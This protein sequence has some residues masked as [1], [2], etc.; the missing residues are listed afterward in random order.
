MFVCSTFNHC[1]AD[2]EGDGSGG[3]GDGGGGEG[4]GGG[5]EGGVVRVSFAHY[6]TLEEVDR[7]I[8]ALSVHTPPKA[9]AQEKGA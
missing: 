6:N 5:G 7:L 9:D 1:D 8:Q 2:E 3:K 4:D